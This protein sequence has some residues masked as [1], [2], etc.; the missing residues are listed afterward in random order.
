MKKVILLKL[1]VLKNTTLNQQNLNQQ[2]SALSSDSLSA[3]SA[4][5]SGEIDGFPVY[6]DVMTLPAFKKDRFNVVFGSTEGEVLLALNNRHK[7]LSNPQVRKALNYA[8]DKKSL[9]SIVSPSAKP[10]GSHYPP[11]RGLC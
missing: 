5:L 4:I 1:I 8:I 7:F 10:I 9:I 6:Q 11:H 3:S 2:N